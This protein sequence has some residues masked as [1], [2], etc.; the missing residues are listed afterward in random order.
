MYPG[1]GSRGMAGVFM[2]VLCLGRAAPAQTAYTSYE[3]FEAW[4]WLVPELHQP[5]VCNLTVAR[6]ELWA[7]GQLRSARCPGGPLVGVQPRVESTR[8]SHRHR[9]WP[10]EAGHVSLKGPHL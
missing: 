7:H 9:P 8:T 1:T 2:L 10:A 5:P 4:R 3:M 6:H